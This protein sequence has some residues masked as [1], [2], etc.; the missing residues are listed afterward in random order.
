MKRILTAALALV[1]AALPFPSWAQVGRITLEAPVAPVPGVSAAATITATLSA[2]APLTLSPAALTPSFVAPAA[3]P[4]PEFTP[5]PAKVQPRRAM[6]V[7][8][9]AGPPRILPAEQVVRPSSNDDRHLALVQSLQAVVAA[10]EAKPDDVGRL[11][12]AGPAA[13][14][15]ERLATVKTPAAPAEWTPA[16]ALL[17]PV[18]ALANAWS[19]SRHKKRLSNR[20]HGDRITVE[21]MGMQESLVDAHRDIEEGRLQ[22]ALG[23]LIRLF[24]GRDVNGW[25]RRNFKF[26]PYQDEGHAYIRF[27][28]RA[29][30]LAYERAHA[31]AKDAVL[32]AEAREA[33]RDGS[34]LGHEYRRT[35]I[36]DKDSAHCAHH[37]LFNAI[38]A[39][40]GFAYPLSVHR[41]VERARETL[42]VSARSLVGGDPADLQRSI[43]MKLG[44]DVGE[45]MGATM[46]ARWASMLGLG[47]ETRAPP[48]G[49]AGW[50]ALLVPG[51]ENLLGLR[52]FHERYKHGA[53]ERLL[54][55]HD[56]EVLHH[57]VYLL[58]AF[59][60][61][62]RGVRL[63]MVQDSGSG[64]TDFYTAEELSAIASDVQTLETHAAVALP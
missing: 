3:Q 50:S 8:E 42:N 25:Y 22:K 21:E 31:R 26:M 55:G 32:V 17:K 12:D 61:P 29:V 62:S 56:Y 30:K 46:I 28:E 45:G 43:G 2:S 44:V 23:E 24:K 59:D 48:S 5:A 27:I 33:A 60:S 51:R 38:T 10:I 6:P 40:V 7:I 16:S 64:A 9:V 13:P 41:F 54:H 1:L 52:M 47:V 49:D 15:L 36:Q 57:G 20:M 35:M 18:A 53:E 4:L 19:L 34:L 11:Y 14:D 58:G 63:Y 39:S 37:A